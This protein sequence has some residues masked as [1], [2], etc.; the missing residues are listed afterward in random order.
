MTKKKEHLEFAKLFE[1]PFF[2]KPMEAGQDS[3]PGL[4]ANT[5]LGGGAR[6]QCALP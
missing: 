3:L 1:K 5:H 6:G 4:H 2:Q